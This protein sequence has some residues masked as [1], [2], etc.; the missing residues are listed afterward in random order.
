MEITLPLLGLQPS[1]RMAAT[2]P[3]T[4][5]WISP[6]GRSGT[7]PTP[8][9]SR[10]KGEQRVF[11]G[12]SDDPAEDHWSVPLSQL[13]AAYNKHQVSGWRD[14]PGDSRRAGG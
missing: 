5:R 14:L 8:A 10:D 13:S 11:A 2:G 4:G 6:S 7:Y 12:M 9:L 1:R 3:H